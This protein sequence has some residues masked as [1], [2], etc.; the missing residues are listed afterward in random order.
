[1]SAIAIVPCAP[2]L[3]PELTG[4]AATEVADLAAAVVTAAAVLPGRWVAVGTGL[5]D[6]VVSPDNAGTFA[7]FGVDV[8]VRLAPE[9]VGRRPPESRDLPLCG[10]IAAWVRGQVRPESSVDVRVFAADQ[11]LGAALA[12]G[13]A[14]R[15]EIEAQADPIGVLVVADGSNTLTARAPGGYDPEGAG[16]QQILD[17][18]LAGGDVTTLSRLPRRILAR[19]AFAVLAGLAEPGPRSAKELYRGAPYGV[20]YFAGVWQP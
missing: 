4:A 9:P 14:L 5:V 10:L 19:V 2:V 18:A 13:R 6:A 17:D 11:E 12:R 16:A 20:G 15:A 1:M 8:P 3:V 7:G